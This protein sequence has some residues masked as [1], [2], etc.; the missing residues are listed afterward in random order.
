MDRITQGSV[1]SIFGTGGAYIYQGVIKSVNED[2]MTVDVYVQAQ[3]KVLYDIPIGILAGGTK[4]RA[5][6][7][8]LIDTPVVLVSSTGK[9]KP[10]IVSSYSPAG[11]EERSGAEK[12]Y[13][14][15]VLMSSSS[16]AGD[17]FTIDGSN[18]SLSGIFSGDH[19][20]KNGTVYENS[21]KKIIDNLAR[22]ERSGFALDD[23]SRETKNFNL[24]S[25]FTFY[26][27]L[28]V[29]STVY[30][31]DDVTDQATSEVLART[32]EIVALI[33]GDASGNDSLSDKVRA[34]QNVFVT[35]D[36]D[37]INDAVAF[38]DSLIL[39]RLGASV[40]IQLGYV[41]PDT[42]DIPGTRDTVTTDGV[43]HDVVLGLKIFD[44]NGNE[45]GKIQIDE[46]CNILFDSSSIQI[47]ENTDALYVDNHSLIHEKGYLSKT[48]S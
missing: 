16:A 39:P 34:A 11:Y 47:A 17:K 45:K 4:Q 44:Q 6:A 41:S 26:S 3:G 25:Q 13:S 33:R 40:D 27:K 14:G 37:D 23:V 20:D 7:M 19:L 12:I 35:G 30:E 21:S 48:R 9:S 24:R 22:T 1:N 15:E 31:P 28:D 5:A 38:L 32:A 36:S 42:S 46:E 2:D 43:A 18:V 10:I 29:R 8:P